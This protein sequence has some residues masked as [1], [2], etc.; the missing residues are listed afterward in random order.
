M[1]I[2]IAKNQQQLKSNEKQLEISQVK[3][4]QLMENKNYWKMAT[5]SLLFILFFGLIIIVYILL[6]KVN[7]KKKN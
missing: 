2:V 3:Q 1:R 5:F 6:K 7:E 4:K